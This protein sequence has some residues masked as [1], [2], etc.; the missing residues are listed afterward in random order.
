MGFPAGA[1]VLD[2]IVDI[3][4][5][6]A[7]YETILVVLER[8]QEPIQPA[9]IIQQVSTKTDVKVIFRD[10]DNDGRD[11]DNGCSNKPGS[12]GLAFPFNKKSECQLEMTGIGR[13]HC[14]Y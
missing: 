10:D 14:L 4:D 2:V 6:R 11:R 3:G 7:A 9:Q 5:K 12:A 13:T 8:G 1:Y